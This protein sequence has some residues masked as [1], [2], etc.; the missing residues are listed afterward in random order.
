MSRSIIS[1]KKVINI[2]QNE[3]PPI[4]QNELP[5]NEREKIV[6][7]KKIKF[8]PNIHTT[9]VEVEENEGLD[10]LS[11]GDIDKNNFEFKDTECEG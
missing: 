7:N 9:T 6:V 1:P 10:F 5:L 3:L 2:I 4:S 11:D 8:L